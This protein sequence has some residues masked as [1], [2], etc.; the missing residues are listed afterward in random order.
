VIERDA[1]DMSRAEAP[2]RPAADAITLDTTSLSAD[3]A[4]ARAL[5]H[6]RAKL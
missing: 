1:R 6:V 4:I 2:L 5:A 3:E